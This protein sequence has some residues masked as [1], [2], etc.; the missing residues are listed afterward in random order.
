MNH[1]NVG[2]CSRIL[3]V[4]GPESTIKSGKL[5]GV[6]GGTFGAVDAMS[7]LTD[8]SHAR[9]DETVPSDEVVE[10]LNEHGK[11]ICGS[12]VS[13]FIAGGHAMDRAFCHTSKWMG[14]GES[15]S[16]EGGK[17]IPI[18]LITDLR[19]DNSWITE[20]CYSWRCQ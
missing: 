4:C 8:T 13:S 15:D 16:V 9:G 20:I 19:D 1:S 7:L 10:R 14:L 6:K 11:Y 17:L 2:D 12:V 5:S 18:S 3:I